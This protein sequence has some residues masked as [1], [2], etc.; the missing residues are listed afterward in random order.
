[1]G[2]WVFTKEHG[3][4]IFFLFETHIETH[5]PVIRFRFQISYFTIFRILRLRGLQRLQ[6]IRLY[7]FQDIKVARLAKVA[8]LQTLSFSGY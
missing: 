1:M 2:L 8:K 4:F 5:K 7:H 3:S 6:D